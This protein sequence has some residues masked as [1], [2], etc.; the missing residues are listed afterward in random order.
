MTGNNSDRQERLRLGNCRSLFGMQSFVV[1]LM[2]G[3]RSNSLRRF[4]KLCETNEALPNANNKPNA[5]CGNSQARSL[6]YKN[7]HRIRFS[8]V[9]TR[10]AISIVRI[11]HI[12][13]FVIVLLVVLES[14]SS[15]PVLADTRAAC[16]FEILQS[17]FRPHLISA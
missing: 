14:V 10:I 13:L 6:L 3:A 17:P 5:D 7:S 11:S 16:F 12:C 1:R 4:G 15:S 9:S 8:S 2:I